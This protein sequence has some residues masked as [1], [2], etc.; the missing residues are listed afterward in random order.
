MPTPEHHAAN[1]VQTGGLLTAL[2][3]LIFSPVTWAGFIGAAFGVAFSAP[4][5]YWQGLLW[6]AFGL[7]CS[8]ATNAW[9]V[10][11][12]GPYASAIAFGVAF[13]VAKFHKTIFSKI[14]GW[15]NR[16]GGQL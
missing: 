13:I 16:K 12:L 3:A 9:L 1:I 5:S 8:L 4:K 15:I 14:D 10:V 11:K 2:V 6:L 7:A